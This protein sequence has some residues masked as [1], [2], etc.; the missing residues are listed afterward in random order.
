MGMKRAMLLDQQ[1][2]TLRRSDMRVAGLRRCRPQVQ[3]IRSP[4]ETRAT[5]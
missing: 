1:R 5:N 2:Q 3:A 4:H